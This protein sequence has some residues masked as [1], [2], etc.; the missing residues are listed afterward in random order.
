MKKSTRLLSIISIPLIITVIIG[1][2]FIDKYFLNN[3]DVRKIVWNQLLKVE[4]NEIIGSWRAGKIEKVIINNDSNIYIL[5]DKSYY[6]KEVYLITFKSRR[7][8]LLGNVQKLVDMK[9]N[10]I[11]GTVM[12]K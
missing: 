8:L 10:N 6:G 11:V 7:E 1:Y 4:Q 9:N 12:R 2:S 5:Y 3:D